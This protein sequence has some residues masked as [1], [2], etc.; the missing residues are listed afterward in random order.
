MPSRTE[1]VL[2]D[3]VHGFAKRV[4]DAVEPAMG[5]LRA[6]DDTRP[7]KASPVPSVPVPRMKRRV[8]RGDGD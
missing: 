8:A 7:R 3:P 5:V 4:D 2:R 1:T 6:R